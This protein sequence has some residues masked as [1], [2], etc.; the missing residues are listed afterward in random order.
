MGEGIVAFI[1]LW[2]IVC[3]IMHEWLIY[4]VVFI[5]FIIGMAI[6]ER[7]GNK[8]DKNNMEYRK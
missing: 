8:K 3:L 2:W 6:L 1:F 5:I 4:F 7:K